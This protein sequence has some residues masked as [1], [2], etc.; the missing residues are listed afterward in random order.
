MI[1]FVALY[2]CI[3]LCVFWPGPGANLDLTSAN[4]LIEP[5]FVTLER[6]RLCYLGRERVPL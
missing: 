2:N 5:R 4:I 1:G 3:F 6:D